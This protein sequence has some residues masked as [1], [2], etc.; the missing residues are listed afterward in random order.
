MPERAARSACSRS[1]RSYA[2]SVG[3]GGIR[4]VLSLIWEAYR[5]NP[6]AAIA[7]SA[8]AVMTWRSS[9]TRKSPA[10]YTPGTEVSKCSFVRT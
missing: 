7:P 10:A 9:L 5:S 6:T 8:V 1:L 3:R 4:P 2:E